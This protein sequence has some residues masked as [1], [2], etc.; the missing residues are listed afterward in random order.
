MTVLKLDLGKNS[1]SISVGR[2]LLNNISELINLKR[3]A[4]IVTDEGVPKEYSEKVLRAAKNA[5]IITLPA[6]EGTKSFKYLELLLT[7]MLDFGLTRTDCVIAVGGGVIGDLAG[8]AAASYMRGID[9][10]NIPTTLLSQVDSSVGGKC[11]INLGTTK[12]TVGAFYQPKAVVIDLDTLKTLDKRLISAGLAESLKMALTSDE[13]LFSIFENEEISDEVIEK[14]VIASLK[15]KTDVVAHD[16]KESGLRRILNF[17]HT[18][19]HGIEA[20]KMGEL[21]HGECVALGMIP[22]VAKELRPR[23]VKVLKKLNLQTNID[24]NIENALSHVVNDKKADGENISVVFVDG[25]A[26]CRISKIKI[27]EFCGYI[28]ANFGGRFI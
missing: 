1:Y 22:M 26:S 11:A 27:E 17:G 2:G 9:F 10:Y 20:E 14:I 13:K 7:K 3:R 4:V 24:I 25:V 16:E 6:G 23:L 18:F 8:F 12:N 5:A 21:Y 15:I 19:G 28:R